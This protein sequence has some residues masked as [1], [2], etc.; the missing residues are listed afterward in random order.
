MTRESAYIVF[1]YAAL[2][3]LEILGCNVSN[4]YLNS[5]CRERIMI[6]AGKEF[7]SQVG[8][9]LII[10]SS[11]YGWNILGFSHAEQAA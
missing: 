2:N 5:P 11:L 7:R 6:E 9:V 3:D 10:K 8:T 1:L 4:A